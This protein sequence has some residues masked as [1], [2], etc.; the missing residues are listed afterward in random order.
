[1]KEDKE[2]LLQLFMIKE[3]ITIG[4]PLSEEELEEL[5]K[6]KLQIE[7]NIKKILFRDDNIYEDMLKEL[8]EELRSIKT[9]ID[10]Q[11]QREDRIKYD[12]KTFDRYLEDLDSVDVDNLDNVTLKRLFYKIHVVD[13]SQYNKELEEPQ[14]GLMFDYYFLQMPY[15]ELIDKALQMGY[16]HMEEL[17]IDI[18]AF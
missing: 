6:K 4:F 11:G 9:T 12:K 3:V 10:M 15:S 17:P 2:H 5:Q 7:G 13:M 1:M 14:R 18:K 16:P 8:E